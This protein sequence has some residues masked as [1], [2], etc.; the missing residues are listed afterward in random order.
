MCARKSYRSNAIVIDR[1]TRLGESDLILSCLLE[2]GE[3]TSAVAKAALKPGGRLAAK[4]EFFSETDFLFAKGKNLDV[5]SE[6][7]LIDPHIGIRGNMEALATASAMCELARYS[8]YEDVED[9]FSYAI[10]RRALKAVEE[11]NSQELLDLILSAYSFK[12]LAH[13]GW[14]P[15][16]SHCV[17][18][19]EPASSSFSP[20][21]GG[22][23]CESCSKDL[24]DLVP[25]LDSDI[26]WL[27]ALIHYTFDMLEEQ[28]IDIQTSTLLLQLAH[29]WA[30]RQLDVR[31][32][33]FEFVLAK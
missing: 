21:A 9:P 24:E 4:V 26:E 16:L 1:R 17:M 19:A 32:R 15:E 2:N 11:V 25:L 27:N 13:Q 20:V 30:T 3:K 33:A 12:V 7:K 6:A 28:T 31:L 14:M 10:L 8:S 29:L 22:L 5:I 18:C 23:V